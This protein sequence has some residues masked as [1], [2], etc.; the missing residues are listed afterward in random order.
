MI[1]LDELI[2]I[3]GFNKRNNCGI[4]SNE[5]RDIS[6]DILDVK[7][8]KGA[9]RNI[10]KGEYRDIKGHLQG[11]EFTKSV[12]VAILDDSKTK[13]S[14]AN[15]SFKGSSIGPWID[16]K[17]NRD[18]GHVVG[19]FG[20]NTPL[21]NGQTTYFAPT[22]KVYDIAPP[23]ILDMARGIAKTLNEYLI[24][25]LKTSQVEAVEAVEVYNQN[26]PNNPPPANNQANYAPPAFTQH[27]QN[28]PEH[29]QHPA[30]NPHVNNHA[31][32]TQ[33]HVD[34]IS[35]QQTPPFQQTQQ[36]N[37]Q[38]FTQ[39]QIQPTFQQAQESFERELPPANIQT[40]PAPVYAPPVDNSP[41]KFYPPPANTTQ[42]KTTPPPPGL[43]PDGDLPF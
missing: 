23:H 38:P 19:L 2:T 27:V 14:L 3:R 5:I 7:T 6:K 20:S 15:F 30:D 35:N 22:I 1:V 36:V 4:F 37:Q 39:E 9:N 8:H 28:Q 33:S 29:Y 42:A 17:F 43:F 24:T 16:E 41:P 31:P 25:Y 26:Q 21:Q 34:N 12:Y 32:F 10:A 18:S 13:V 40:P 11:G